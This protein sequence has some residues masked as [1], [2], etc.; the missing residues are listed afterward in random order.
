[1]EIKRIRNLLVS[2]LIISGCSTNGAVKGV[3]ARSLQVQPDVKEIKWIEQEVQELKSRILKLEASVAG[4][5]SSGE[6]IISSDG[7]KNISSW[8]KLKVGMDYE[9]VK[10]ILGPAH[11]IEGGTFAKWRYSND[12]VVYFYNAEVDRWSEPR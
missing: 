5:K 4:I 1:M 11:R 12:G 2:V 10:I 6:I 8:R 7:W 3:Q 9:S